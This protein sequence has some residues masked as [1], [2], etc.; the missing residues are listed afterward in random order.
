MNASIL[1][2]SI[3]QRD[4]R[5]MGHGPPPVTASRSLCWGPSM[6]TVQV[7][8]VPPLNQARHSSPPPPPLAFVSNH[9]TQGDFPQAHRG[10]NA[11][12]LEPP[13]GLDQREGPALAL[14]SRGEDVSVRKVRWEMQHTERFQGCSPIS[15]EQKPER[16]DADPRSAV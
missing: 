5:D 7:P 4:A 14:A 8:P 1:L 2:D 12:R 13:A 11:G 15:C 6:V 3:T 16:S 10:L 9:I